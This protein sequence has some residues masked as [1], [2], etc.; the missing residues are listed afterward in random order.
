ML[1]LLITELLGEL[2]EIVCVRVSV[3]GRTSQIAVALCFTNSFLDS[4]SGLG[5]YLLQLRLVQ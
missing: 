3:N 2:S 1:P 4:F 5:G